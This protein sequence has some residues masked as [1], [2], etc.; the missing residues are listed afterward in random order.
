MAL[1]EQLAKNVVYLIKINPCIEM[2]VRLC[3]ITS[4][5]YTFVK[6]VEKHIL[7]F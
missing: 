3:F 6:E 5:F 2:A 7:C 1:V 4:T